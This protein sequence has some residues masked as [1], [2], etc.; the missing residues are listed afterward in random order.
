MEKGFDSLKS[1]IFTVKSN[2]MEK[3]EGWPNVSE[4]ICIIEKI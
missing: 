2:I 3:G 1:R 4:L